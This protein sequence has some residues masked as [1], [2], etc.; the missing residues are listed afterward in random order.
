MADV[1]LFG[2]GSVGSCY[3]YMLA[4]GGANTTAV[5]RSN[6]DQVKANG[7]TINSGKWGNVTANPAVV[8]NV[9]DAARQQWDYVVVASKAFPGSSPTTAETI[10]PAIGPKTSI[11]LLQNGIGIEDEYVARFPSNPLISAC[12]YL[13]ATQTA[14]GV[15]RMGALERTEL[16]TFPAKAPSAHKAAAQ[17]FA[18]LLTA[19]NGHVEVYE[20]VQ[21]RRWS[22]LLVNASW[23][24][25]CALARSS[26]VEYMTSTSTTQNTDVVLG[27][28]LELVE[29]ANALGY[30][31]IN[32]KE[33][34]FQLS[35]ATDRIPDKGIEPSMLA[36]IWEDRPMEV[37]AI[38]GNAVRLAEEK[39]IKVPGLTMLYCLTKA[40][41]DSNARKRIKAR[42]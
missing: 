21:P 10:A 18:D 5:C 35:R 34:R 15:I 42:A 39:G 24:P 3:L 13:P 14:Q 12:V 6:Y 27:V 26:D 32:E 28:M 4:N 30:E 36:D 8:R 41:D 17:A 38:V 40:L 2:A 1:L 7:F 11:V 19:G 25:I 22:K 20:D 29:L 33:A 9:A 37:E 23:N 16:G 31:E